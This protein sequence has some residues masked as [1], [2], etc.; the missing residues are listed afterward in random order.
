MLGKINIDLQRENLTFVE[1]HFNTGDLCNTQNN[2]DIPFI[3]T[4]N[5][6]ETKFS[7]FF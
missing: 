6:V 4:H 5:E 1:V 2:T 7:G 3:V